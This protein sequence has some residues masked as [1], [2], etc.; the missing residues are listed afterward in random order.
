MFVWGSTLPLNLFSI[1]IFGLR[2]VCHQSQCRCCS[3]TFYNCGNDAIDFSGST[4]KV[5]NASMRKIGDKAVSVG[6]RASV[7]ISKSSINFAEIGLTCKDGS[8]LNVD[9]AD[10]KNTKIGLCAFIKKPEYG[11]AVVIANNIKGIENTEIPFL[12]EEGSK[13]TYDSVHISPTEKN[14]KSILY[15]NEYGKSSK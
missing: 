9:N 15:G 8:I 4:V 14:V 2:I 5:S 10:F 13:I 12:I 11:P 1:I 6:E 7:S 3:L